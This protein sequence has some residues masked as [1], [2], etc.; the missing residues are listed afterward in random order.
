[1]RTL[2]GTYIVS[3]TPLEIET[4]ALP[5]QYASENCK[6]MSGQTY[7][8]ELEHTLS[9]HLLWHA[10]LAEGKRDGPSIP[11]LHFRTVTN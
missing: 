11:D 5:L 3:I 7:P 8:G 6:T 1:M 4:R 2:H 9:S 10:H